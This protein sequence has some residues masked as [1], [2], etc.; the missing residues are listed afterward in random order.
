MFTDEGEW[1]VSSICTERLKVTF[2]DVA[3]AR[4]IKS[5]NMVHSSDP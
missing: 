2:D 3:S 5:Q 1:L 4:L